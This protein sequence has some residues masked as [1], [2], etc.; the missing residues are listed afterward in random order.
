LTAYLLQE[1]GYLNG[2][3]LAVLALILL[4]KYGFLRRRIVLKLSIFFGFLIVVN[5]TYKLITHEYPPLSIL[6][7]YLI[8]GALFLLIWIIFSE[9][10]K[11]YVEKERD[12]S[13]KLQ[14]YKI[15]NR[16]LDRIVQE[17]SAELIRT[18]SQL[19]ENVRQLK[20][21]EENLGR[22]LE[23]K[24]ALL[25]EVHHRVK[26]NL[27]V[28]SSLLEIQMDGIENTEVRRALVAGVSRIRTMALIHEQ[29]YTQQTETDLDLK[30][31]IQELINYLEGLYLEETARVRIVRD[32]EPIELPLKKAVPCGLA[33]HECIVNSM[34]HAFPAE[35]REGEITVS[36]RQEGDEVVL[37]VADNGIGIPLSPEGKDPV[38]DRVG[39]SLGNDLIRL[40]VERQLKGFVSISSNGGTRWVLRFPV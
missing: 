4:I 34:K 1:P 15:T 31:Y 21:S 3:V 13:E 20:E 38:P 39:E 29:V 7:D 30:G 33:V 16:E 22:A 6:N 26:N 18:N 35:D 5:T 37:E 27:A 23:V 36:G 25:S 9:E 14:V 24:E 2:P 32:I 28:I 11:L 17:S 12:L 8:L 40:L 10:I 19:E